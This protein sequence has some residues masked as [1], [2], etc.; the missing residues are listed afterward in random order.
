[1]TVRLVEPETAPD[2]A[3]IVVVPTALPL[4]SPSE[5]P[6]FEIVATTSSEE[7]HVTESVRFCV[8]ASV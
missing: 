2:V 1:M 5:P 7:D 3:V 6:A 8:E 4:A